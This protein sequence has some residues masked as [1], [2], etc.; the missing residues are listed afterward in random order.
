MVRELLANP[1]PEQFWTFDAERR[2]KV[3][4]DR[5]A[6]RVYEDYHQGDDTW[7]TQ[8]SNPLYNFT[9]PL[10]VAACRLQWVLTHPILLSL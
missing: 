6:M 10:T 1:E 2:Y 5:S 7:D 9:I 4:T 8:V 3:D